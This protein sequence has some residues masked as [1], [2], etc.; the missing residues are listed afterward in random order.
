MVCNNM[1]CSRLRWRLQKLPCQAFTFIYLLTCTCLCLNINNSTVSPVLAIHPGD[2]MLQK[3]L[4]VFYI[5]ICLY[6]HTWTYLL[7]WFWICLSASKENVRSSLLKSAFVLFCLF[8]LY[9]LVIHNSINPNLLIWH[10]CFEQ[11]CTLA[12]MSISAVLYWILNCNFCD[13]RSQ[14]NW[15]DAITQCSDWVWIVVFSMMADLIL[16]RWLSRNAQW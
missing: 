13:L 2:F 3:V 14:I 8:Y 7:L 1:F 5:S 4:C 11:T 9:S 16:D 10:E 12:W 15:K 6:I